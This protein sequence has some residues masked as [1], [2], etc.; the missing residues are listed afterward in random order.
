MIFPIMLTLNVDNEHLSSSKKVYKACV[1][2]HKCNDTNIHSYKQEMDEKLLHINPQHES[3]NV[4]IT[5][6]KY[7]MTTYRNYM[8]QL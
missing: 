2:W 7:I 6:V 5:N 4:G 8:T 3:L 1:A